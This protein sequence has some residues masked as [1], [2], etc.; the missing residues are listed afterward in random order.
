MRSRVFVILLLLSFGCSIIE[1]GDIQTQQE[2]DQLTFSGFKIEQSRSGQPA[3]IST[4]TSDS[5]VNIHDDVYDKDVKRIKYF[6]APQKWC[7][8]NKPRILHDLPGE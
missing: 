1:D 8:G 4:I 5:T 3:I 6:T 7:N 2:L